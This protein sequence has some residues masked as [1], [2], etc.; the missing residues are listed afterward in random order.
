MLVSE[1]C[2]IG[3]ILVRSVTEFGKREEEE[4]QKEEQGAG[5]SVLSFSVGLVAKPR[6]TRPRPRQADGRTAVA[7][8]FVVCI[9][10]PSHVTCIFMAFACVDVLCSIQ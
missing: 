3:S 4:K 8:L 9:S 2:G 7:L 10:H 6:E 1:R 5:L